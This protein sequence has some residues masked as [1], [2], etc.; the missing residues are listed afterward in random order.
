MAVGVG[1]GVKV[2]LLVAD[3][4]AVGGVVA[5]EAGVGVCVAVSGKDNVGGL[6]GDRAGVWVT[7]CNEFD[8]G[9]LVSAI[10]VAAG[11]GVDDPER[12][13]DQKISTTRESPEARN[14]CLYF[15]LG[16]VVAHGMDN[17]I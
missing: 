8:V 15:I 16:E 7:I 6:T 13:Q 3:G 10:I 17:K 1:S 11:V 5:L 4:V 14:K 12:P 9:L 2:G